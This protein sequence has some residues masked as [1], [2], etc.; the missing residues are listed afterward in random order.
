MP[1]NNLKSEHLG[2][3]RKR[4][5]RLYRAHLS[6][7]I[8][9]MA[10]FALFPVGL[11]A[12]TASSTG[13]STALTSFGTTAQN[14][15]RFAGESAP[16]NQ[17]SLSVGA[18]ALYDDNVKASNADRVGDEAV[19][20]TS[21]LNV[22]RQTERLSIDFDYNPFF[23]FYRQ[24]S[25]Y[26]RLNHVANLALGYRLSPRYYLGLHDSFTYLNGALPSL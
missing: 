12:Q 13:P 17:F 21:N 4:A 8:L 19:S 20:F 2:E 7:S 24:T 6:T 5:G 15:L 25:Q 16:E 22:S 14:P 26:D 10:I 1:E 3:E 11:A 18:S 9:S 23:L